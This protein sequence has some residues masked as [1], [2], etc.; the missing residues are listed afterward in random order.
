[1]SKRVLVISHNV[2]SLSSNMGKT[3]ISY[4]SSWNKDELAEFYIHSEV[5]TDR[6][7]ENYY[8]I[9]DKD[10]LKSIL[11][12]KSG[13]IFTGKDVQDDRISART[14]EGMTAKIYQR[15][16]QRTPF[17]YFAR[18][19]IWSLGKWNTKKFERWVD[20]FDPEAVFFASG[21]YAFMYKI[22]L[23]TA[24]KRNI[25]LYICCMDDFYL[26]NKNENKFGGKLIHKK[27][28]RSVR[29]AMDYATAAFCICDK[30][31]KEYSELF[32]I[33][34]HT[35]HTPSTLTERLSSDEKTNRIS[36]IGNLGYRRNEQLASLGRALMNI[37][38]KGKPD[39]IDVYSGEKREDILS[40]MTDE[41]GINFC[42]EINADEVKRVMAKSM[43]LIH[44][45]SFDNKNRERVKYS[46]STKIADS[47]ASGTCLIAY[48]PDD[49]AS[50]E[51]L[52]N[53]SAAFCIT[54]NDNAEDMLKKIITDES[55]QKTVIEN[56]LMLAEKNHGKSQASQ[57]IKRIMD[58]RQCSEF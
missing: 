7:T 40:L 55:L 20:E 17:I 8:R 15:S 10:M 22:A 26:N 18:N 48:G 5:P 51:Y 27:F 25:P 33:E 31:S 39:R 3:L 30:M 41:N 9:T 23:K 49:V 43:L 56:A 47:L 36:Y 52:I 34:S 2:L 21:D 37:D 24:K 6:I 50:M 1:M 12:R 14:D 29:S 32:G 11:K 46:V 38:C 44:T 4:F 28:M 57:E 13:N 45:E 58:G 53:N 42:G 16:R 54:Q 35:L 19:L